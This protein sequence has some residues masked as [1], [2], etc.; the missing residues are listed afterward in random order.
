MRLD[1]G[2]TGKRAVTIEDLELTDLTY[3]WSDGD[4]VRRAA[5]A[6][7]A[8]TA[9]A[10]RT[11]SDSSPATP[12][13]P[14]PAGASSA[15]A[16][17]P[18]HF[19]QTHDHPELIGSTLLEILHSRDLARAAAMSRLTRYELTGAADQTFETLSGG[20]QAR[21]QI[22]LLELGGCTLLLLDEPTDNLDVASAEALEAAIDS[23][24]GTVIAVTHDRW[25]MQNLD[26]FLVFTADGEVVE[27]VS[28][29]A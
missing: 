6:S 10:S 12:P 19:S 21:F 1:G 8:T 23:F 4:L 5:R 14:T 15:P 29:D 7:S 3:P 25:F 18:G 17:V 28:P 9:P 2:R 11:C 20:Q 26:R 13:S 16:S 22:L 27:T 24:E